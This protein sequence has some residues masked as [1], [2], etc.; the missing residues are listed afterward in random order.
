MEAG[1]EVCLLLPADAI[2]E[3]TAAADGNDGYQENPHHGSRPPPPSKEQELRQKEQLADHEVS[4][5]VSDII[6]APIPTSLQPTSLYHH[7]GTNTAPAP[8]NYRLSEKGTL[9]TWSLSRPSSVVTDGGTIQSIR[10]GAVTV[11]GGRRGEDDGTDATIIVESS[12][13]NN[14]Q[15][16]QEQAPRALA[17][18][19]NASVTT[20]NDGEI[21]VSANVVDPDHIQKK[22]E[23]L[24]Q[25]EREAA[26]QTVLREMTSAELVSS[27]TETDPIAHNR[28]S[29]RAFV[30]IVVCVFVVLVVGVSVGLTQRSNTDSGSSAAG[31]LNTAPTNTPSSAPTS[32]ECHFCYS[33]TSRGAELTRQVQNEVNW[34]IVVA[35]Q[36]PLITCQD[37]Y[38]KS[39]ELT[40]WDDRCSKLQAD[41]SFKCGCPD[42]PAAPPV[43]DDDSTACALCSSTEIPVPISATDSLETCQDASRWL[44]VIAL[45]EAKA[46][47]DA[48]RRQ[49]LG[50]SCK[51]V[52]ID[53]LV[54][55]DYGNG[56]KDKE[57]NNPCIDTLDS[58]VL[59]ETTQV[60]DESIERTYTLCPN[61]IFQVGTAQ[62]SNF[63]AVNAIVGGQLPI[64]VRSNAR[65]L[66]G[67]DGSR[68]NNCTIRDGSFGFLSNDYGVPGSIMQDQV[69]IQGISFVNVTIPVALYT[70]TNITL[71][72]CLFEASQRKGLF[73]VD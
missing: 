24:L 5:T 26:R 34:R 70:I 15:E 7:G 16:E 25:I 41:A 72:D 27:K 20:N 33:S 8:N 23:E 67:V 62:L 42:F 69:H 50:S 45:N 9:S 28:R 13:R 4:Q 40:I 54:N 49:A 71:E 55:E 73:F 39:F 68:A 17:A 10:P 47:C 63:G 12:S 58:I 22:V 35:S 48:L 52:G 14:E 59:A 11:P 56:Q 31:A 51:C 18:D 65:V 2:L 37:A 21:M 32:T 3:L 57:T 64:V 36:V 43:P 6:S 44:P 66:C 29:M 53:S 60:E 46:T 19:A 1:K 38:E 61:T 30:L